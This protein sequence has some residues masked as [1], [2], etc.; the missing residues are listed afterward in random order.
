[1]LEA[2]EKRSKEKYDAAIKACGRSGLMNE[3]AGL[4]FL[5]QD[6]EASA[7]IHLEIVPRIFTRTGEPLEK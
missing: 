1:M 4:Y 5:E 6:D 2:E 3:R 7:K